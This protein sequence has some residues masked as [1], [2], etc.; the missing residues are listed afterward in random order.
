MTSMQ[1]MTQ[2]LE[3][4]SPAFP[5]F[6]EAATLEAV[7]L[8]GREGVNELFE[9]T[10]ILQTIDGL[11][12][13]AAG[14]AE[15][16]LDAFLGSSIACMVQLG[17]AETSASPDRAMRPGGL[18]GVREINGL[19]ARVEALGLHENQRHRSFRLTL[20]PWLHEATLNSRCRAFDNLTVPE[21]LREVLSAYPFEVEQ[22][23]S[24]RYPPRVY[25]TQYNETDFQFF[26][27]ITQEH[28]INYWFEHADGRHTLVL[29]DHM[30]AFREADGAYCNV[31]FQ[32]PGR[33]SE[34]EHLHHLV[35]AYR[36]A[37]SQL[38]VG[39]YDY[40]RSRRELVDTV[41]QPPPA[42]EPGEP[43]VAAETDRDIGR[44]F[45]ATQFHTVAGGSRFAQAGR[46][47]S[48]A[49]TPGE[50][51]RVYARLRLEASRSGIHRIE[52][53]GNLRGMVPGRFCRVDQP[54][55]RPSPQA[56]QLIL[57][58]R[59]TI[60]NAARSSRAP[61]IAPGDGW[62]VR[63]DVV[64]HPLHQALR[65]EILQPRP[66]AGGP[67][68]GIVVGPRGESV[69]TDYLGRIQVRLRYHSYQARDGQATPEQRCTCWLRVGTALAGNQ[70][71]AIFT[72]RI[73]QEVFVSFQDGDIDSPYVSGMAFNSHNQPPW[74]LPQNAA[75][76]GIRSREHGPDGAGNAALGRGNHL[77]LDDTAGQL[78]AQLKSDH[79]HSQ[80]ILG[81]N[82]RIEDH[83]GRKEARGDGFE[84]RT[85]GHG[86]LR[87]AA[88]I[89]ITNEPRL[90]AAGHAKSLDETADRLDASL[91][92]QQRLAQSAREA[93]AQQPGDQDAVVQAIAG[94]ISEIRGTGPVDRHAGHY[95]E[96]EQP[97]IVAASAADIATSS[98]GDTH[99]A[100][101]GHTALASAGHTSISTGK[102]LFLA[103]RDAFKAFVVNGCLRLIAAVGDI[104]I[105]AL[106][107]SILILARLNVR[108]HGDVVYLDG[109]QAVRLNGGGSYLHLDAGGVTIGTAGAYTLR[110]GNVSSTTED[111]L[112]VQE[113]QQANPDFRNAD[114]PKRGRF[115]ENFSS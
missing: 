71:G 69:H 60:D 84:L 46:G 61:G 50:D 54:D 31:R 34:A 62:N 95:P 98:A 88:G 1:P 29:A 10:V 66:E 57:W 104:E 14:V 24:E 36:Q 63:V 92:L 4:R 81:R 11:H 55:H 107:Q 25:R 59:L 112:P 109:T 99:I 8:E 43:R 87:A 23:L 83:R 74:D 56:P 113:G 105:K 41:R 33:R 40:M 114:E 106:R 77:I 16:R 2:T 26:S 75:L 42:R 37:P 17:G 115:Y 48:A 82:V 20:R 58:T 70:L 38:T 19:I 65:P 90:L 80:L 12:L 44:S 111:S 103:V 102:G 6:L 64:L 100:S 108:V 91:R 7:S 79:Q 35:P 45:E 32:A 78:Q 73:G 101:G 13:A 96:I 53:A 21:V 3:A 22:R 94:Q 52:A 72:P 93:G 5:L 110:T 47:H 9:Y 51:G 67:H 30:G 89:F 28:G 76:V 18:Q 39:D 85:D 86:V 97:H 49:D 15:W 68:S 27:R